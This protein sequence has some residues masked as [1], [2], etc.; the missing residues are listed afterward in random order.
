MRGKRVVSFIISFLI[1]LQ[2]LSYNTIESNAFSIF[3]K[4]YVDSVNAPAS[5][6]VEK[7]EVKSVKVT[8]KVVGN[9]SKN[10]DVSVEDKSICKASYNAKNGTLKIKGLKKG[11]TNIVL[12]TK[13][14]SKF[15]IKIK[16]TIAVTITAKS[17]SVIKSKS[18]VGRLYTPIVK[19]YRKRGVKSYS[20]KNYSLFYA[21]TDIN[22]DKV[23]ELIVGEMSNYEF[24]NHD[25][26]KVHFIDRS[27]IY[28]I[29]GN[30]AVLILED[31]GCGGPDRHEFWIT[32]DN[33][34]GAHIGGGTG[35][36][37]HAYYKLTKSGELKLIEN[38]WYDN[39]KYTTGKVNFFKVNS[40]A[41]V[42]FDKG[43]YIHKDKLP[44]K[45]CDQ[46][47]KSEYERRLNSY[48]NE[49]NIKY[50]KIT[51]KSIKELAKK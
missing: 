48:K 50:V 18:K 22:G 47:T 11:K 25:K 42:K 6:K 21:L 7:S 17:S 14:S 3:P 33:K 5:V 45:Y 24:T 2:T 16:K 51:D 28:T 15:Y 32:K 34:I 36:S 1:I 20:P 35:Y 9:A 8:V 44:E 49:K 37:D 10:L 19:K 31:D 23:P 13:S 12:V 41:S 43:G 30:K 29:K 46:I 38:V 39:D 40:P 26:S 4:N 27:K